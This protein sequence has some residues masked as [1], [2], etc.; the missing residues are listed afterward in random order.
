[1]AERNAGGNDYLGPTIVALGILAILIWLVGG[2]YLRAGTMWVARAEWVLL[3]PFASLVTDPG[4]IDRWERVLG[5]DAEQIAKMEPADLWAVLTVAGEFV[6]WPLAAIMVGLAG[7]IFHRSPTLRFNRTMNMET[8][9]RVQANAFPRIRPILHLKGRTTRETRGAYWW[10]LNPFEWAVGNRVIRAAG[11]ATAV[12]ESFNANAAAAGFAGQ[13]GAPMP[14][15]TNGTIALDALAFHEELM[16]A[17]LSARVMGRKKEAAQLM[18]DAAIGFGPAW[19]AKERFVRQ[20]RG[21]LLDWPVNGPWEIVLPKKTESV[22]AQL[23]EEIQRGNAG[24]PV[25]KILASHAYVRVAIAHLMD[26]A[27]TTGIITTSDFIWVKAVDRTLHYVL[28]D[29]GRRVASSE[30]SGVRS[31][32]IAERDAGKRIPKPQVDDAVKA[33]RAALAESGWQ[34]PPTVDFD[35]MDRMAKQA[36]AWLKK[37]QE[38]DALREREADRIAAQGAATIQTGDQ[39]TVG[40]TQ[41]WGLRAS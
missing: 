4:L 17:I 22:L 12:R 35:E 38:L 15:M 30:A 28:N 25:R 1:M 31:H 39:G 24:A 11:S 9:L 10:P 41:G 6:R 27:Q 3:K 5:R 26:A 19:S 21:T 8:L 14:P 29:V 20:L 13:L 23:R 32:F 33:L 40:G 2:D 36:E 7:W 37:E 16:I 18:D 34:A